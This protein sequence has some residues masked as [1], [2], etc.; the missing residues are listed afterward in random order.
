MDVEQHA[1]AFARATCESDGRIRRDVVALRGADIARAVADHPGNH[2]RRT[3]CAERGAILL[4]RVAGPAAGLHN[5]IEPGLGK[6]GRQ[7]EIVA[8]EV[9]DERALRLGGRDGSYVRGGGTVLRR[10]GQVVEDAGRANDRRLLGVCERDLDHLNPEIR[11]VGVLVR[12]RLGAS[13]ELTG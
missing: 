9:R 3:G 5:A 8:A 2:R 4:V 12:H 10:R 7:N 11:R 1:V 6:S 13:G